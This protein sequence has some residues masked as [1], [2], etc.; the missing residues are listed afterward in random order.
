MLH[1]RV[2][3]SEGKNTTP[4]PKTHRIQNPPQTPNPTNESW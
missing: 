3:E 4:T 2:S 1:F